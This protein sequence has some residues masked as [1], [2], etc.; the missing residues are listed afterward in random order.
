MVNE[1][2]FL[3]AERKS[4]F[5]MPKSGLVKANMAYENMTIVEYNDYCFA[6]KKVTTNPDVPFG[7]TFECHT[8]MTFTNLGENRCK[9]MATVE[10]RF[11]GKPPMI[12]W[13]I[14]NGMYSG[15]TDYFVAMGEVI[16]ENAD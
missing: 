2:E 1:H 12:A 5:L 11:V 6:I 8:L 16:C 9:L 14:K 10:A 3:G 15:V 13:K 7:T 4:Q